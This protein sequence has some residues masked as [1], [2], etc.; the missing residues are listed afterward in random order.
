[1]SDSN[2]AIWSVVREGPPP[3]VKVLSVAQLDINSIPASTTKGHVAS[4][5][6]GYIKLCSTVFC[7]YRGKV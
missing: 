4:R 6:A 1:M 5:R 7:P 3:E 2:V